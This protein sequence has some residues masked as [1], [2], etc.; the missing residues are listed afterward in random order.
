MYVGDTKNEYE[1]NYF[2]MLCMVMQSSMQLHGPK[3]NLLRRLWIESI[4]FVSGGRICKWGWRSRGIGAQ[5]GTISYLRCQGLDS[6]A[7]ILGGKLEAQFCLSATTSIFYQ[8]H[9]F[10]IRPEPHCPRCHSGGLGARPNLSIINQFRTITR[11]DV[12]PCTTCT[13]DKL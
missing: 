12:T 3:H 10:D 1:P 2:T 4:L 7:A 13:A 5:G 8:T 11:Q 9:F 6:H